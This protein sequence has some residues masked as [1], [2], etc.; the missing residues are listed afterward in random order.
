MPTKKTKVSNSHMAWLSEMT[1]MAFQKKK[2]LWAASL[3]D[4]IEGLTAEQAA[5]KPKK[6]GAR[7]I[8]EIVNHVALWKE[9]LTKRLAGVPREKVEPLM[10]IAWPPVKAVNATEWQKSVNGLKSR[11]TAFLKTIAKFSDQELERPTAQKKVKWGYHYYG[12]LTHDCYHAGQ[13]ILLR[14]LQGIG[15]AE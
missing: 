1:N 12:L 9:I 6:Q 10:K 13:V 14:E 5:W 2:G 7:S 8:W 11:Q 3:L 4:T 15:L